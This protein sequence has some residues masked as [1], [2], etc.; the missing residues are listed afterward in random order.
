MEVGWTPAVEDGAR[1]VAARARAGDRVLTLGA[2]DI[3]RAVAIILE[4]L[5]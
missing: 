5:A 4:A 3:D 1:F 2:G